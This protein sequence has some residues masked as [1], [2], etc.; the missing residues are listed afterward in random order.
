M[1]EKVSTRMK[2]K[3]DQEKC[4]GHNLAGGDQN[5]A[6]AILWQAFLRSHLG[7]VIEDSERPGVG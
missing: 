4:Q 1:V 5:S 7:H 2:V 3:V 6:E